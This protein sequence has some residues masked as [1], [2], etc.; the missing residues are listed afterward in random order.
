MKTINTSNV[1]DP[2][3]LQPFT[4]RSL[5]FLQESKEDDVAAIIKSIVISNLGTYSLTTPYVISGCNVTSGGMVVTAGEVFFRGKYYQTTAI[6]GTSYVARFFLTKT[7]DP[8]ADP[9]IFSDSSSKNVHDIYKYVPSDVATGGDFTASDLVNLYGTGTTTI[10][11]STT[12]QDTI[13][14]NIIASGPFAYASDNY[15]YSWYVEKGI[16]FL[17]FNVSFDV[18]DGAVVDKI[19]L[20]LPVGLTKA[21]TL[22]EEQAFRGTASYYAPTSSTDYMLMQVS[23]NDDATEGQRITLTRYVNGSVDIG[24]STGST[25]LIKGSVQILLA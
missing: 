2:S 16:C 9:L 5:R 3:V 21:L 24:L 18:T 20:P 17:N 23:S 25:I 10:Q 8:T 4:A 14:V 1:L 15:V 13:E 19:H 7:Q 22:T 11:T 6:V 12:A